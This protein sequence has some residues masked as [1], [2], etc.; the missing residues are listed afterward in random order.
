MRSQ[1]SYPQGLPRLSRIISMGYFKLPGYRRSWGLSLHG[2]STYTAIKGPFHYEERNDTL[3]VTGQGV[4]SPYCT[5]LSK[6]VFSW[7]N[8]SSEI[9]IICVRQDGKWT[10]ESFQMNLPV[11]LISCLPAN[12]KVT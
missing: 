4:C 5:W 1:E 10:F 8:L 9:K 6:P 2:K 7:V 11:Y 3:V 12:L